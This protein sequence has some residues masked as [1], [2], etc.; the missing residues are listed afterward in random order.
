MDFLCGSKITA[1]N[2]ITLAESI[3]FW[4]KQGISWRALWLNRV[5]IAIAKNNK[6]NKVT[7]FLTHIKIF[8][9]EQQLQVILTKYSLHFRHCSKHFP[10]VNSF[11]P[12]NNFMHSYYYYPWFINEQ[13]D[14]GG[15]DQQS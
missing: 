12:L 2:D 15:S 5:F 4:D 8:K 1:P 9:T 10:G 3:S 13:M 7:T 6:K 11:Y 14:I